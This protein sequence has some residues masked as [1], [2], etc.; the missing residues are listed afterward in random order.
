MKN[1]K[2]VKDL[3]LKYGQKIDFRTPK[4]VS[5]L[6]LPYIYANIFFT[7]TLKYLKWMVSLLNWLLLVLIHTIII[8]YKY[9]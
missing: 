8:I 9:V 2:K 5:F 4:N 1:K 3:N 6:G 7:I